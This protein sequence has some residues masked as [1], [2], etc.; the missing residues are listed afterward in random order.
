M[1][2]ASADSTVNDSKVGSSFGTGVVWNGV[3]FIVEHEY[4]FTRQQTLM[5]YA[6][7]GA[8]YVVGAMSTGRVLRAIERWLSPRGALWMILLGEATVCTGPWF[9]DQPWMIIAVSCAISVLSSWLWPIVESYL[10]AG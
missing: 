10:T 2:L 1:T 9:T 3:A 6:V 4:G 5:L 7:L 8:T